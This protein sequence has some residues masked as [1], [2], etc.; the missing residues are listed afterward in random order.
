M[1]S[2][3]A[4]NA[5]SEASAP[6]PIPVAVP[7][8]S[9]SVGVDPIKFAA[10]EAAKPVLGGINWEERRS[11]N[12]RRAG[13]D[14]RVAQLPFEG[15][16][17]RK[18]RRRSGLD[19]RCIEGGF[20]ALESL[21]NRKLM[22]ASPMTSFADGTL[23]VNGIAG[24]ENVLRVELS[25]NG[26]HVRGIANGE[27]G[28]WHKV[29]DV[30]HIVIT[31]SELDDRI[32]VDENVYIP[33]HVEAGAGNDDIR[34][35]HGN[36]RIIA[37]TG[38][39]RVDG[40]AGSDVIEGQDGDDSLSGSAGDDRIFGGRGNDRLNGDEG[41]DR[42]DAGGGRDVLFGHSGR[43]HLIGDSDDYLAG[44]S[45]NDHI[46]RFSG[47]I[48]D[49]T[50][51]VD[52]KAKIT[53]F[54]LVDA[55]TNTIIQG[56]SNLG[57]G[58]IIDLDNLPTDKI[59]I[60]AY[61]DGPNGE[62]FTG[63]VRF[64]LDGSDIRT[65]NARPYA[66]FGDIA[67]N[68]T[69]WTPQTRTY[70]IT[71][72]PYTLDNAS[73]AAGMART[74]QL[75]F[76][77]SSTADAPTDNNTAHAHAPQVQSFTLFDTTTG[78]AVPG[79]ENIAP[80]SRIEL[81][82]DMMNNGTYSIRANVNGV[83]TESVQFR[84]N[85]TVV[86]TEN[87]APYALR[88]DVNAWYPTVGQ[89]VI[90][91]QPFA[92][93]D[94][95]GQAG[96]LASVR[97]EVVYVPASDNP[98]PATPPAP[99]PTTPPPAPAPTNPN[100]GDAPTARIDMLSTTIRAGEAV[101]VHGLS[102]TIRTGDLEQANFRWNFG[103]AGSDY[104]EMGGFNAAHTYD[105]PGT[106][107]IRL[108]V[109][110]ENGNSASR[111]VTV[112]VEPSNYERTVYVSAYGNDNNDGSTTGTAVRTA[113]RAFQLAQANGGDTEIL[114]R[115]GQRFDFT[116]KMVV[117]D[118]HVRVGAWG[119]GDKP[120]MY[121]TGPQNNG[122]FF[123]LQEGANDAVIE[124][125]RFDSRWQ[126]DDGQRFG[127][128]TAVRPFSD[129]V[130]IRGNEFLNLQH[131]V[132]GNAKPDGLLIQDN[133]APSESGVRGYFFWAEGTDLNVIG[134][135]AANSVREHIVRVGGASRINISNNDFHNLDRTDQVHADTAKSTL[136][137]QLG[138]FAWIEDNTLRATPSLG[139]LDGSDGNAPDRWEYAVFRDNTVLDMPL[140]V[141]DGAEH[142][143]IAGNVFDM[144][145]THAI[146]IKGY[147][148]NFR[149][150][151]VDISIEGN[152]ALNDGETGNFIRIGTNAVDIQLI[153][154]QYLAPNLILG[155][156]Q[157]AY[158]FVWDNNASPLTEV[159]D[160]VWP[161][162]DDVI[163]W[164]QG[165]AFFVGNSVTQS[166]YLTP[167]E[168]I[169]TVGSTGDVYEDEVFADIRHLVDVPYEN[170]LAA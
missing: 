136:A 152:I 43:D 151:P 142:I 137:I 69:T 115:R 94:A 45:G 150:A 111:S 79:F 60:R 133:T 72:T 124:G 161:V 140:Q 36:D 135:Y 54:A 81:G 25:E 76:I 14:R 3:P 38:N 165:G 132:L 53:R 89:H 123:E 170:L 10:A 96:S 48:D 158:V 154:N 65:E 71:A 28:P 30:R 167:E 126:A 80:G 146:N 104:N 39:D 122:I 147:D 163:N 138:S 85:G 78:Q 52:A 108:Q 109:I 74:L 62:T 119:S 7:K 17:R 75:Q 107:T 143:H 35:S 113:K 40:G 61:A 4:Q 26:S 64:A 34:T 164:A 91:A 20:A 83:A 110:D 12:E 145:D 58:S 56:Y 134:N 50:T 13:A 9:F 11:G 47:Y 49:I 97:V 70:T 144:D 100:N 16:D 57:P 118:A 55:E 166:A 93:D 162:P 156:F 5:S 21:E 99:A 130:V 33:V 102:S 37:G 2:Q 168:W 88:G 63:S 116:E 148:S 51:S 22:S 95:T 141:K 117:D 46:D 8:A 84:N 131:A 112:T 42:L 160:N 27:A 31:G 101:F 105:T 23:S 139:P 128:P 127:L 114:F 44:G 24:H 86:R 121:W 103:D 41:D 92:G 18:G 120:T 67:G 129:R 29:T 1:N 149:R 82:S 32:R 125:L 68:Y 73:G 6:A 157:T 90:Q 66:L 87:S 19:R 153:G 77:R 59:N 15:P 169:A 159:R 98:T 155:Q 106:Y